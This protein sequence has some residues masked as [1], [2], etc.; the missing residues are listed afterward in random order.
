MKTEYSLPDEY[1]GASSDKQGTFE[2]KGCLLHD[3]SAQT[4]QCPPRTVPISRKAKL[5][6]KLNEMVVKCVI[7]R[8]DDP[9]PWVNQ[10]SIQ[11]KKSGELRVCLDPRNLNKVLTRERYPLPT[12][13]KMLQGLSQ[14]RVFSKVDCSSGYWHCELDEE[15]PPL[16][17]FITPFGCFRYWRLPFG[18]NVSCEIF[19]RKLQGTQGRI[20]WTLADTGGSETRPQKG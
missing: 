10:C 17:T 13:D 15:L 5:K 19:Q 1:P 12:L 18:L 16:T 8:V 4:V 11:Q 2:R 6:E 14:S 20:C 3:H 7:T 9:T